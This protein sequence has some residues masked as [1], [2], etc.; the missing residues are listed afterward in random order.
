MNVYSASSRWRASR[1]IRGSDPPRGGSSPARGHA[2]EVSVARRCGLICWRDLPIHAN[3]TPPDRH[4]H[5]FGEQFGEQI[6]RNRRE[7]RSKKPSKHG[8]YHLSDTPSLRLGAG[9]SQV[10]ILSPRLFDSY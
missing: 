5:M 1:S 6:E 4:E 10:Q 7:L 3:A 8:L 9:R 2:D